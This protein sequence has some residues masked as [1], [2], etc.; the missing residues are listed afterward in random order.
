VLT[1]CAPELQFL[2]VDAEGTTIVI[3]QLGSPTEVV[4]DTIFAICEL[5]YVEPAEV[6]PVDRVSFAVE[7]WDGI[8]GKEGNSEITVKLST[9]HL[10]TYE[11][12]VGDEIRGILFHELTHAYQWDG[13]DYASYH[14]LIEGMADF[15]RFRAGY[16][17]PRPPRPEETW[18]AGYKT[19]GLFIAWMDDRHPGLARR[20][21]LS[22]RLEP[23]EIWSEQF[24]VDE[25]GDTVDALWAEYRA[26][27]AMKR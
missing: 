2:G 11:G 9:R 8:A 18:N 10:R 13:N 6:R 1:A 5:L 12:R 24:F 25:T 3:E 26:S 7:D 22:L 4:R 21:N 17:E 23:G 20:L 16:V 15:V 14:G 27:S 19:T